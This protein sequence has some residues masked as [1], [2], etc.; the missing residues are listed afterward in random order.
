MDDRKVLL[1]QKI[2]VNKQRSLR[3]KLVNLLPK[4]MSEVFEKS[5]LITSP[6]FEKSWISFTR[7]GTMNYTEEIL[8]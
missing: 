2:K 3:T 1:Q 6:E 8:Q 4:D 5:E 7:N